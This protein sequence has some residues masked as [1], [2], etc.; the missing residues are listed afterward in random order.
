VLL[1]RLFVSNSC[2]IDTAA[3]GVM[4]RRGAGVYNGG[5]GQSPWSWLGGE[6]VK[7]SLTLKLLLFYPN[8]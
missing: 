7:L 1:T 6:S 8:E 4:T 2:L 3:L 5:L